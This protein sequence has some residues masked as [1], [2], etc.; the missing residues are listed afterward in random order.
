MDDDVRGFGKAYGM[1]TV[2]VPAG[3]RWIVAVLAGQEFPT[4]NE[5]QAWDLGEFLVESAGPLS[6][7]GAQIAAIQMPVGFYG[8]AAEALGAYTAST[9]QV[10]PQ[11]GEGLLGLGTFCRD[12]AVEVQYTKLLLLFVATMVA[13]QLLEWAWSIDAAAL[14]A[15]FIATGRELCEKLISEMLLH[16]GEIAAV[17]TASQA[18]LSLGVQLIQELLGERKGIDSS[19]IG[20]AAL[21][22]FEFGVLDGVA[23]ELVNLGLASL[24]TPKQLGLLGDAAMGGA[25]AVVATGIADASDPGAEDGLGLGLAA[26]SGTSAGLLAHRFGADEKKAVNYDASVAAALAK[27][28]AAAAQAAAAAAR[29]AA[30]VAE[31]TALTA[32]DRVVGLFREAS[33]DP[34]SQPLL[35]LDEQSERE[36]SDHL[37]PSA[38]SDVEAPTAWVHAGSHT[39]YPLGSGSTHLEIDGSATDGISTVHEPAAGDGVGIARDVVASSTYRPDPVAASSA[40]PFP[41]TADATDHQLSSAGASEAE[42]IT[43]PAVLSGGD[44]AAGSDLGTRSSDAG[45]Q[46]LSAAAPE[47]GALAEPATPKAGAHGVAPAGT[48]ASEQRAPASG[49]TASP[50]DP[51]RQPPLQRESESQPP[52]L[53]RLTANSPVEGVARHHVS[54]HIVT[55]DGAGTEPPASLLHLTERGDRTP[56]FGGPRGGPS[57]EADV[58]LDYKAVG[59]DPIARDLPPLFAEPGFDKSLQYPLGRDGR[60]VS[61]DGIDPDDH[62]AFV[63]KILT[64]LAETD[65]ERLGKLKEPILEFIKQHGAPQTMNSLVHGDGIRIPVGRMPHAGVADVQHE[66]VVRLKPGSAADARHLTD[67][68][69]LPETALGASRK[70]PVEA[71]HEDSGGTSQTG[72]TTRT[73]TAAPNLLIPLAGLADNPLWSLQ[74]NLPISASSSVVRGSG[75][76][77]VSATKRLLETGGASAVFAFDGAELTARLEAVGDRSG[78]S[79]VVVPSRPQRI[80]VI[81][82]FREEMAPPKVPIEAPGTPRTDALHGLRLGTLFEGDVFTPALQRDTVERI[83]DALHGFNVMAESFADVDSLRA[84]VEHD[85]AEKR[86]SDAPYRGKLLEYLAEGSLL[87]HF[88]HTSGKGFA[89]PSF[90]GADA[91]TEHQLTVTTKLIGVR[92]ID[93]GEVELKEEAQRFGNL[94]ESVTHISSASLGPGARAAVTPHLKGV[95]GADLYV[96]ADASLGASSAGNVSVNTGSGHI[97]GVVIGGETTRY[98]G[99]YLVSVRTDS[100][101]GES[102][103]TESV[104][105]GTL[106]VPERQAKAFEGALDAVVSGRPP[107]G[108]RWAPLKPVDEGGPAKQEEKVYPPPQLAAG[109]G[110]EFSG[111]SMLDGGQ[112]VVGSV[113][114]AI[115]DIDKGSGASQEWS[116]FERAR[117][118]SQLTA[119]FSAEA[120]KNWG[121]SLFQK[122]G[123]RSRFTRLGSQG[124]ETITVTVQGRLRSRSENGGFPEPVATTL[125]ENGKLEVMPS[126]FAGRASSETESHSRSLSGLGGLTLTTLLGRGATVGYGGSR[127]RGVG[128]SSGTG[129]SGFNLQAILKSGDLRAFLYHMEF[130][131]KVEVS[132]RASRKDLLAHFARM[133]RNVIGEAVADETPTGAG[134]SATR[135]LP[136]RVEFVVMDELAPRTP[137][138]EAELREIGTGPEARREALKPLKEG[139]AVEPGMLVPRPPNGKLQR[140][141]LG[142]RLRVSNPPDSSVLRSHRASRFS[143]NS[144]DQVM[145]VLGG[146][147]VA[148]EIRYVLEQAGIGPDLYGDLPWTL[149]S[150]EVLTSSFVRGHS[151]LTARLVFNE[152]L[153]DGYVDLNIKILPRNARRVGGSRVKLFHMKVREGNS[154]E[155]ASDAKSGAV[156]HAGTVTVDDGP[157]PHSMSGSQ[158]LSAG[159]SG[160]NGVT[161]GKNVVNT[162]GFLIQTDREYEPY[163]GDVDITIH[164]IAGRDNLVYKGVPV[165]AS[166]TLTVK[167]GLSYLRAVDTPGGPLDGKEDA[168]RPKAGAKPPLSYPEGHVLSTIDENPEPILQEVPK[169]AATDEISA[170]RPRT[171]GKSGTAGGHEARVADTTGAGNAVLET[172]E[173]L[174]RREAPELLESRWTEVVPLTEDSFPRHQGGM[175][176][177]VRIQRAP[178]DLR[179]MQN[180]TSLESLASVLLGPGLVLRTVR[181]RF[182]GNEVYQIVLRATRDPE[183]KGYEY[184]GTRS[185]VNVARYAFGFDVTSQTPSSSRGAT[186]GFTENFNGSPHE[187]PHFANAGM[188]TGRSRTSGT[189]AA[190]PTSRIDA[191]RDTRFVPG[192]ADLYVG[193]LGV[194]VTLRRTFVPWK[195]FDVLTGGLAR[196]LSSLWQGAADR[197]FEPPSLS[198][199]LRERIIVPRQ[200]QV[201]D[202]PL[203]QGREDVGSAEPVVELPPKMKPASWHELR[204]TPRDVRDGGALSYGFDEAKLRKLHDAI[205]ERITGTVMPLDKSRS[206]AVS[207]LYEDGTIGQDALHNIFSGP[208]F[209]RALEQMMAEGGMQFPSQLLAGG[210]LTA[211]SGDV[212][213]RVEP[214]WRGPTPPV[215]GT[216]MMWNEHIKYVLKQ[217]RAALGF[218]AGGA[219]ALTTSLRELIGD[220]WPSARRTNSR[221]TPTQSLSWSS[222]WSN[223]SSGYRDL[224][225][226]PESR[227]SNV[228]APRTRLTLDVLVTIR[229]SASHVR[230]QKTWDA[231]D[232][233]QSYLVKDALELWLSPELSA[234]LGLAHPNKAL[235]V[236]SGH[237]FPSWKPGDGAPGSAAQRVDSLRAA[238][239]VPQLRDQIDGLEVHALHAEMSGDKVVF[240]GEERTVREFATLIK[241][242]EIPQDKPIVLVASGGG[243]IASEL[244]GLLG[245]RVEATQGTVVRTSRGIGLVPGPDAAAGWVRYGED[246]TRPAPRGQVPDVAAAAAGQSSVAS[247]AVRQPSTA[248][249]VQESQAESPL[250]MTPGAA[251]SPI[252][253][254]EH[255]V[256]IDS[257]VVVNGAEFSE[258]QA[259]ALPGIPHAFA[260][261]ARTSGRRFLIGDEPV[262]ARQFAE[263]V[264]PDD[265]VAA[266]RSGECVLTV[267]SSEGAVAAASLSA[268]LGVAVLSAQGRIVPGEDGPTLPE[269]HVWH[270][271]E[272]EGGF[273]LPTWKPL[274]RDLSSSVGL[275]L[276]HTDRQAAPDSGSFGA[277]SASTNHLNG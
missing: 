261:Y 192:E 71:A 268:E 183:H 199:R 16:I 106:R 258:Q 78:P 245:R 171:V 180:L 2:E 263:R 3:L 131:V 118:R 209:E 19:L 63:G 143:L 187:H 111:V 252:A 64:S 60:W 12:F 14:D 149:A 270:S 87:R 239:A 218:A 234:R 175:T 210:L 115:T 269:G 207:S 195:I 163:H 203:P 43:S 36:G 152:E 74:V 98:V 130:D 189:S 274:A 34:E 124:R 176:G 254:H 103:L 129:N 70:S 247:S 23:H 165:E 38:G 224:K 17:A 236:P 233:Q 151:D 219:V 49:P 244:S 59:A 164:A 127:T 159:R 194:D 142:P 167:R 55:R 248:P 204:I 227:G 238:W 108:G 266:A 243:R 29:E 185:A 188:S 104:I 237:Y 146:E 135:S 47:T 170:P 21:T 1:N 39:S 91:T 26:L 166:S 217:S 94:S 223:A 61:F 5:G 265:I 30:A 196:R 109:R 18:L 20:E 96:E 250:P 7:L 216:V 136:G 97:S 113:I 95:G 76:D 179:N 90:L 81:V 138:T 191:I 231:G 28:A 11:L 154:S 225:G 40:H 246:G 72:A 198:T 112:H 35:S 32:V 148:E 27:K 273:S 235:P 117:L 193:D 173:K 197:S 220:P 123:V 80:P 73:L 107:G 58:A 141:S 134:K 102:V 62:H 160:T 272:A 114:D 156:Q 155:S 88:G 126:A 267:V 82:S 24:K 211:K 99:Q 110:I 201:D 37:E 158:S 52:S 79:G 67:P 121:S 53:L 56:P 4:A 190:F 46:Q 8:Q 184:M 260:V 140:R 253:E 128:K 89:P 215:R 178:K 84:K 57:G 181:S 122:G 232:V 240:L 66:L 68:G 85:F 100:S 137:P 241:E 101:K 42:L 119:K 86:G 242:L 230:G 182:F 264:L 277:R 139:A 271:A 157:Y 83:D 144:D 186:H 25:L 44:K 174:L 255:A 50:S 6:D 249:G 259:A 222:Q 54:D 65:E 208:T 162:N 45:A 206:S 132:H 168:F 150:S 228:S 226:M 22:G 145:D 212:T 120:L 93:S 51:H 77:W 221:H 202:L 257:G 92:R 214:G 125:I 133:L 251:R 177:R 48:H 69:E 229:A 256:R 116:E 169:A 105:N 205:L 276:L 262:D 41:D 275:Q 75:S 15:L 172:I 153:R 213:V 10:L 161:V 9:A 200:V 31:K 13:I 33:P 147:D